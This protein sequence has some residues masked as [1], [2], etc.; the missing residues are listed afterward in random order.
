[1]SKMSKA[2]A[3]LGVVAGLG[4]AALPLSSYAAGGAQASK[5]AQVKAQ[6]EG[7]ISID[8]VEPT[9]A[10]NPTG[11]VLDAAGASL[12]LGTLKINAAPT[13]GTM[14]VRVATNNATGY[15]LGIK[16]SSATDMVGSDGAEGFTIPANANVVAGTAGWA[17][18]GGLISSNTAISTSD[19]TLAN[20][21]TA[22]TGDEV[23]GKKTDVT[24]VTFTVAADSTTHDGTYTGTVIFTATAND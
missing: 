21:N 13:S 2:I 1:M 19:A 22:L 3:V 24:E 6:V 8:I 4:V 9:T 5:S 15:T 11:V 20:V 17:Y 18:K 16:A 14:G 23:D 10:T 7:A 12:D